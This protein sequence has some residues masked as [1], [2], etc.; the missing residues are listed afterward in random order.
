MT[1]RRQILSGLAAALVTIGSVERTM[2][3]PFVDAAAFGVEPT[4]GADQSRALQM[5]VDAAAEQGQPLYLM[6]GRYRVANIAIGRP[7]TIRS[8][9]HATLELGDGDA[10]L[11]IGDCQDVV[12]EGL[13]LD[14]LGRPG[15]DTSLLSVTHAKGVMLRDC[16]LLR[17]GGNG[18]SAHRMQGKIENCQLSDIADTAIFSTDSDGLD[19]AGN[20]IARCGNGGIRVW[21]GESGPDG[22]HIWGNRIVDIDWVDGGNGQNG[23]GINVFRADNVRVSDNHLSKCAFSAIRLNTTN[24]TR[25]TGNYCH[26]S[27]EVSIFSEFGFSGSIISHNVVEGGA[28]GISMTNFDHD[29]RLSV[30]QGNIVRNLAERSRTNPDTVPYGIAAEADAAVTG[31]IVEAVPGRGIVVGW[32]PYLRD[33]LVNDNLV[34][35]C[36]IGIAVSV[37]PGAGHA[38]ISGNIVS[39]NLEH[40]IVG[41]AWENVLSTDLAAEQSRF[42]NIKV[43]GNSII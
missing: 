22:S 33:V 14:G 10:V 26:D 12:L 28:A 41:A 16:R 36:T 1:N 15:R 21:R 35:E 40:A 9:A 6:G 31:N 3:Q 25:V 38:R 39:G 13:T 19:I 30:C 27:G 42:P 2:S 24:N 43:E 29:G 20:T 32:G 23:N 5:A 7:V 8:T 18:I 37:A 17:A 11:A 4:T 34:R